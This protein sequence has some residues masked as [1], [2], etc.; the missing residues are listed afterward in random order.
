M[1]ISS[2]SL[3]CLLLRIFYEIDHAYAK[4]RKYRRSK[5]LGGKPANQGIEIHITL[6]CN[7]VSTTSA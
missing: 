7:T 6:D 4:E 5:I 1:F 3:I 2:L